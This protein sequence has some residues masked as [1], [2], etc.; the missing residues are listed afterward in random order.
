MGGLSVGLGGIGGGP[1]KVG[2]THESAETGL[3]GR[4]PAVLIAREILYRACETA[5]NNELTPEQAIDLYKTALTA[6]QEVA[7]SQT[8]TGT[9]AS[10]TEQFVAPIAE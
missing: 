9:E 7:A 6:I 3:G 10:Q 1:E 8:G 2:D 5:M 4:D